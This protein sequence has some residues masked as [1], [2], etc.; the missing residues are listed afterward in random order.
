MDTNRV[1]AIDFGASSG[2][3]ILGTF[4]NGQIHMEEIHRFPNDPVILNGTMYWDTLRLFHEIKQCMIKANHKGGFDSLG[5]DTWGVDF[6]LLDEH[7]DLLENSIHY[8]DDRTLGM[9]EEVFKRFPKEDLYLLTGNQFE[10]FN[11]IFQLMGL[12]KNRPWVLEKAKKLLLTPDLYNYFLT[13]KQNWEYTIAS[14]TQLVDAKNRVWSDEVLN[15]IGI[16][17]VLFGEINPSGT[18]V[19]EVKKEICDE[20]LLDGENPPKVIAVA[21]HDTQSAAVAV[22]TLEE[23]FVF[24]SCGTWSLFG[25]ELREPVINKESFELQVSNEGGYGDTSTF[26]KNI[27]GLWLIQECRRTWK[28]EGLEFSY[29][30]LEEMALREEPFISFIDPDYHEFNSAGDM[31]DKIK[32]FCKR[33]GQVVPETPGQIV[34]C[35]DQSLAL[36]Y[37]Y[38]LEQIEHCT[39]KKYKNIHMIGGG[40]QSK[41]LCEMTACA[42]N[43][44]VIAGPIEATALGNIAVQMISLGIIK[45]LKTVRESISKS[46]DIHIYEPQDFETWDKAY[47]KWKT[48]LN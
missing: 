17:G 47:A 24:I 23:D 1:L 45:D 35:I 4:E 28:H 29:G 26:L 9:Q 25:T 5:I 13:G 37:R 14:T 7:G 2:R 15:A 42:N 43:K 22:P 18:I 10:N 30:E 40:I 3:A 34:R 12:K 21:G 16:S 39:K 31:P 36:K 6:G 44:K 32:A 41:M 33:T 46:D 20:L 8:R 11:T 27:I 38:A 19:G 48:I